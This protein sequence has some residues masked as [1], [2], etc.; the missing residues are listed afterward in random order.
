MNGTRAGWMSLGQLRIQHQ[1]DYQ[2]N[3]LWFEARFSP[4][5]RQLQRSPALYSDDQSA[6]VNIA[7]LQVSV[8]R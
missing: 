5:K 7:W 6:K 3:D 8:Q 4:S 2:A 1:R